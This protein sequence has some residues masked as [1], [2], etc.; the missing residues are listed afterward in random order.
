MSELAVDF[1]E[2]GL[3]YLT[4]EGGRVPSPQPVRRRLRRLAGRITGGR[5][6]HMRQEPVP[7]AYR[8][9]WRQVGMDPDSDRT[10]VEELALERIKRGG[11]ASRSLLDE[12]LTIATLETGVVLLAFDSGR[13]GAHLGLRLAGEGERLGGS[14]RPLAGGHLVVADEDR[15]LALLDGEVAEERRVTA[16]TERVTVA[17]IRVKGVPEISIEEALWTVSDTLSPAR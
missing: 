15:P 9:F 6:V 14:G 7:A 8:A 17:S 12:A 1:P 11:L 5:V 4:I 13:V 2:L 16:R 10:P 3:R